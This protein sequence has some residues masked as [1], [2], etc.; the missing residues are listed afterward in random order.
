MG[1]PIIKPTPAANVIVSFPT[2]LLP[3]SSLS[4]F[5]FVIDKARLSD[6]TNNSK[7]SLRL[8]TRISV[9]KNYTLILAHQPFS[10]PTVSRV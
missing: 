3:T 9:I 2:S 10:Q 4:S 7:T 5:R 1:L 6:I 8:N